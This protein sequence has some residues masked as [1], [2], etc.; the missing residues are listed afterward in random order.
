[1]LLKFQVIIFYENLIFSREDNCNVVESRFMIK[2]C[3]NTKSP[4]KPI[5]V[6]TENGKISMFCIAC[7]VGELAWDLQDLLCV[8]VQRQF[9][10]PLLG[11]DRSWL[12]AFSSGSGTSLLLWP[13]CAERGCHNSSFKLSDM[14][15]CTFYLLLK[16]VILFGIISQ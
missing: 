10:C 6:S 11:L 1:M 9:A 5:K 14:T 12:V 13:Q 15:L 2:T 3:K 4:L 8:V 16:N 7:N